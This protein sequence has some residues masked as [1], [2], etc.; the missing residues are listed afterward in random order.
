MAEWQPQNRPGVAACWGAV[1]DLQQQVLGLTTGQL[2]KEQ[3]KA[4]LAVGASNAKGENSR[5]R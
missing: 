3:A 4:E 5:T 1:Q 2:V